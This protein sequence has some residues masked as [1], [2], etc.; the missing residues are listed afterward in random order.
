MF[1]IQ[2]NL[3]H[4]P[5]ASLLHIDHVIPNGERDYTRRYSSPHPPHPSSKSK[6]VAARTH[7]R[8]HFNDARVY[9]YISRAKSKQRYIGPAEWDCLAQSRRKIARGVDSYAL[10]LASS[11]RVRHKLRRPQGSSGYVHMCVRYHVRGDY[12]R[13][14]VC[15]LRQTI[16]KCERS[17]LSD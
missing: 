1:T 17:R 7:A 8:V 15:V 6:H 14:C 12:T 10:H 4:Q 13:V 9:I 2:Y 5:L 3:N 16:Y 11:S